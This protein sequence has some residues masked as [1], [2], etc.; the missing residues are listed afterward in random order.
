[1]AESL[2]KAIRRLR[3]PRACAALKI[4]SS[5]TQVAGLHGDEKGGRSLESST[6]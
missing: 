1:M 2:V 5:I 3:C 4:S 6:W